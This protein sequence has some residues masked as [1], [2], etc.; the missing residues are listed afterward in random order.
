M[1]LLFIL[2]D[3]LAIL[4]S[5]PFSDLELYAFAEPSDPLN[6]MYFFLMMFVGTALILTLG[7]LFGGRL[8]KWVLAGVTWSS[9]FSTFYT[10]S[11]FVVGDPLATWMSILGS[12]L[13]VTALIK[14]PRWYLIDT[15]ALLL[16]TAAMALIGISI[17]PPF[18]AILLI[19]L[20][21]YDAIA[22]YGTGH[23]ISLAEIV[24]NS[25]LPL[26]LIIPK[27]RDYSQAEK[28]IILKKPPQGAENRKAVYMG[29]GDIVLPGCLAI[30]VYD[31]LGIVALPIV[32]AI[33]IGT[34]IGFSVLSFFVAKGRPQAG[35]P[36]LCGGAILG[37]LISSVF[38]MHLVG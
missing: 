15:T 6:I 20:A 1:G 12:V 25:G 8:V 36:Y 24:I 9:L 22:V 14:W 28:V 27:V 5:K 4:L 16:G 7:R 2:T 35:L 21:V 26:V 23:M 38:F 29:L 32:C 11:F 19:G 33:I 30:S 3:G 13:F 18:M 34:L 37:Y 10:F 31:S 17:R